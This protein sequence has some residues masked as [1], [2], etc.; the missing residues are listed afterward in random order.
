MTMHHYGAWCHL[1]LRRITMKTII[2]EKT[3]LLWLV[4][5]FG[6]LAYVFLR[7]VRTATNLQD[8]WHERKEMRRV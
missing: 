7:I 2:D 6:I 8:F 1:Q 5:A 4:T 3:K